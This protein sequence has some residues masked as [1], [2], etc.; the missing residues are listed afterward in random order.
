MAGHNK[1]WHY[2][3]HDK[4]SKIPLDR[5]GHFK[6]L[7]EKIIKWRDSM[8][9]KSVLDDEHYAILCAKY[10]KVFNAQYNDESIRE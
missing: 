4:N 1:T 10:E 5:W 8:S 2:L 6:K 3:V 9:S 7:V